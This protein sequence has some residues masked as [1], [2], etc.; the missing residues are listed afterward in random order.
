[1]MDCRD[2]NIAR[3]STGFHGSSVQFERNT[4]ISA[5]SISGSQQPINSNV[6]NSFQ[7]VLISGAISGGT[8]GGPTAYR[9]H[10]GGPEIGSMGNGRSS[11]SF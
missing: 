5:T 8:S 9:Y 6:I 1:M 10:G 11:A 3:K 4:R 7:A 2:T